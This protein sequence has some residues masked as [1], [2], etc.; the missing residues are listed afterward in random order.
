MQPLT[1]A[2]NFVVLDFQLHEEFDD[3]KKK[4]IEQ[5][6]SYLEVNELLKYYADLHFLTDSLV[7]K[8]NHTYLKVLTDEVDKLC[9][10]I[11][12]LRGSFKQE[13]LRVFSTGKHS[14]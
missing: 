4:E 5:G 13:G 10:W 6:Y 2:H 8:Y 3:F 7:T 1:D 14:H 9:R 11:H 12:E